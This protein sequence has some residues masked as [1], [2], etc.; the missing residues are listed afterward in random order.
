[1]RISLIQMNSQSDT[2]HNLQ[3]A[4]IL[5]TEAARQGATY[6]LLPE[7][8]AFFGGEKEKQTKGEEIATQAKTFLA[9]TAR[10]LNLTIT[11]GGFPLPAAEGKFYNAAVTCGSDGSEIHRYDKLHLFDVAPGDNVTYQESRGTH[12]GAGELSLLE[13]PPF[14]FGITICYDVRFAALYRKYARMGANVLCVPAAFTRLTGEAHW[15]TLLRA[16]AI[17]NTCYVL[18]AAQVGEH[19]GGRQT[20][21]HSIVYDPWGEVVAEL[22]DRPGVVVADLKI[23]RINEVRGRMPSLTHDKI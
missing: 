13:L 23:E 1:M 3:E 22:P 18:A 12:S 15:H 7:N 20:F 21:G 10:R 16:R 14:A 11:G 4:A 17:E 5:L 19:Y 2:G 9:E 6:A 8:F